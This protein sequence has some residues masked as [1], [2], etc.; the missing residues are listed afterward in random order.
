MMNQVSNVDLSRNSLPI[1]PNPL[2]GCENTM[3]RGVLGAFY[4]VTTG[5]QFKQEASFF[6]L[7]P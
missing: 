7:P 6:S 2:N 1:Y 4:T 5:L 3:K